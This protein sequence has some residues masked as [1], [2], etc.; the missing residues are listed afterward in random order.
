[1]NSTARATSTSRP[2]PLRLVN[3]IAAGGAGVAGVL[4]GIMTLHIVVD[5]LARNFFGRLLPY[6]LD[7]V[8]YLW[9]PGLAILALGLTELRGD[10]I[11]VTVL[12]DALSPLTSRL[13]DTLSGVVSVALVGW[14]TIL[15]WEKALE[16]RAIDEIAAGTGFPV[17]PGRFLVAIGVT[18]MLAGA[19]A[20]IWILNRPAS[21]ERNLDQ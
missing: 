16:A 13:V 17:W 15:C 2:L 5:V 6:T 12:L 10:H 4:L 18:L 19:V 11:R 1:M 14:V 20:R 3:T 9:M 8:Q 21:T 7:V